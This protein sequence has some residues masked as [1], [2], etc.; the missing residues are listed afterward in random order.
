MVQTY[1]LTKITVLRPLGNF[2]PQNM[3]PLGYGSR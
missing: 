2:N 1:T 3:S